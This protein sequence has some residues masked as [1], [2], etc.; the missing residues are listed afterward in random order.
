MQYLRLHLRHRSVL[1]VGTLLLHMQHVTLSIGTC[2]GVETAL[3]FLLGALLN[4]L[5]MLAILEA[6]V[7]L[8]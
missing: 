3:R 2:T 5:S 8:A 6:Y 1:A 4:S 7:A